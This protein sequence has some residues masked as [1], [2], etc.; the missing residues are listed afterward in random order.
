MSTLPGRHWL[1]ITCT[2]RHPNNDHLQLHTWM[3]HVSIWCNCF[4][5][6]VSIHWSVIELFK[7]TKLGLEPCF[8]LCDMH[9][10]VFVNFSRHNVLDQFRCQEKEMWMLF[11]LLPSVCCNL[12][13]S[14]NCFLLTDMG[15]LD[16]LEKLDQ[17]SKVL[18]LSI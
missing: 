8:N 13:S 6:S 1:C 15:K 2:W 16:L 14:W 3:S 10:R 12:S 4:K 17:K 18:P 7:D 11:S 5:L 9:K